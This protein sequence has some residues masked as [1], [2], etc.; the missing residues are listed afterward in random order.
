LQAEQRLKLF[1]ASKLLLFYFLL[2]EGAL[3]FSSF[4]AGGRRD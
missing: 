3:L 4:K 1:F 2:S